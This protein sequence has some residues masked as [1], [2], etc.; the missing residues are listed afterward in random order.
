M[1]GHYTYTNH[2]GVWYLYAPDRTCIWND[3]YVG[4]LLAWARA[5]GIEPVRESVRIV[6]FV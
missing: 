3:H 1:Y 5:R 4:K 2:G 6:R